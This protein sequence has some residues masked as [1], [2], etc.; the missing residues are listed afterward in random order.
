MRPL[1]A[2]EVSVKG[3]LMFASGFSL[4][5][6][7]SAGAQNPPRPDKPQATQSRADP[8]EVVCERVKAL[9][10]RIVSKTVCMTRLQ[11]REQKG[12]DRV[13]TEGV[14]TQLGALRDGG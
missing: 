3:I 6:A 10:S 12:D 13:F 7:A 14:Q 1:L 9:G 4:V 5:I 2:T 8:G 11:W